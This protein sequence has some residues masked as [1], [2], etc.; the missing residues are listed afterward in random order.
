MR[1]SLVTI[2]NNPGTPFGG[3]LVLVAMQKACNPRM[4][5]LLSRNR[6]GEIS[7]HLSRRW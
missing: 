5:Y 4:R 7:Y 3:K 2:A 6:A 1:V